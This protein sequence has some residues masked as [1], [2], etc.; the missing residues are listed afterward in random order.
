MHRVFNCLIFIILVF[1][2]FGQESKSIKV[3]DE[4]SGLPIPFVHVKQH[5]TNLL[6]TSDLNGVCVIGKKQVKDGVTFSCVGYEPLTLSYQD[7]SSE[8]YLDRKI[9]EIAEVEIYPKDNPADLI[10]Q[11]VVKHKD[12]NDPTKK[13][14]INFRSYNKL[15]ESFIQDSIHEAKVMKADS[16]LIKHMKNHHLIVTESVSRTYIDRNENMFDLVEAVKC[17]GLKKSPF[18]LASK[19]LH[20]FSIYKPTIEV[21]DK[22]YMSPIAP[23]SWNKYLFIIEDTLISGADTSIVI[24]FR[25][26]RGKD[27]SALE[28]YMEIQ[29]ST[30]G[31]KQFIAENDH[32]ILNTFLIKQRFE[33]VYQ[34]AL[35]PTEMSMEVIWDKLDV[36]LKMESRIREV[37]KSVPGW[38]KQFDY[39]GVHLSDSS[40]TRNEQFW[41][42][43]RDI[44]LSIK[45]E[46]TYQFNDSVGEV[47]QADRTLSLMENM[48]EN[49]FKIGFLNLRI[50]EILKVNFYENFRLGL[51]LE[52]NDELIKGLSFG[53]SAGY[54]FGVKKRNYQTDIRLKPSKRKDFEV[55]VMHRNDLE[56]PGRM[57]FVEDKIQQ[58]TNGYLMLLADWKNEV[59][60]FKLSTKFRLGYY[61]LVELWG[62]QSE[63][64]M[65]KGYFFLD[66][67]TA[68][69]R[70]NVYQY[71]YLGVNIKYAFKERFAQFF[72]YKV[73]AGSNYP[74]LWVNYLRATEY[75]EKGIAYNKYTAKIYQKVVI[76]RLGTFEYLLSGGVVDR[77]VPYSELLLADASLFKDFNISADQSF[78]TMGYYE[79]ASTSLV[80]LFYKHQLLKIDRNRIFRPIVSMTHA[81]GWGEYNGTLTKHEGKTFESMEEGF[82]ESGL[83]LDNLLNVN[84]DFFQYGIGMGAFYRY[85]SYQHQNMRD[86]FAF[87]LSLAVAL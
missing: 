57:R 80:Q 32:Q 60:E 10:M 53:G 4:I 45:E 46:N 51:G 8:I 37:K 77:E 29:L 75:Q 87:K 14:E 85:G 12:E 5:E 3:L 72:G 55:K 39:V 18:G 66:N 28:G 64:R 69:Q 1:N 40:S 61:T 33:P 73:S 79:F 36:E 21:L 48:P 59:E 11:Q 54:S 68:T 56:I 25:S 76:N 27:F 2:G 74:I 47:Y 19:D 44:L 34:A 86:N 30:W 35:F 26:K 82:F 24:S 78:Q 71:N 15:I 83:L 67:E 63:K 9:H 16:G 20:P 13:G 81:F 84:N 6:A 23:K 52:T 22:A 42:A 31:V 38:K 65:T 70:D 50:R 62:A 17:S 43:E 7:L 41:D 58:S 49:K